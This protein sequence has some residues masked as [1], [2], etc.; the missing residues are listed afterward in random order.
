[1]SPARKLAHATIPDAQLVAAVADG[2]LTGLATLFDRYSAQVRRF[3]ARLGVGFADLD[4]VV[5]ETFLDVLGASARFDPAATSARP[6]IFGLAAMLVRRRRRS[7]A[8]ALARVQAWMSEPSDRV[9]RTPAQDFELG[10][11]VARAAAA[12]ERLAPRKRETFVLV[13]LEEMSCA[14]AAIALDVPVAT[15]WSRLHYARAELQ[16]HLGATE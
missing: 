12:L 6:W 13:V 2:D 15:V 9:V 4:D 3:V 10:V 11:D 14:D 7:F 5:Q 8:R 1:M 16:A